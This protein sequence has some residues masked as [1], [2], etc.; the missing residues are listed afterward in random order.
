MGSLKSS[1]VL[2]VCDSDVDLDLMNVSIWAPLLSQKLSERQC[3]V[4]QADDKG[5]SDD[6]KSLWLLVTH[7]WCQFP[8]VS[9]ECTSYTL[10]LGLS[11]SVSLPVVKS[12]LP[13][14]MSSG[15]ST[16]PVGPSPCS[17]RGKW[18]KQLGD[19]H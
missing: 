16:Q 7:G 10:V 12:A 4:L 15:P 19:K 9:V 13:V 18:R 2:Q 5:S 6:L 3:A 17:Q 14:G 11:F 1:G 8:Q